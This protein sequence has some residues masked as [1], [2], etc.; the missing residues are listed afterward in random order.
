MQGVSVTFD[1]HLGGTHFK[2]WNEIYFCDYTFP[3]F[4]LA[5][6]AI[7]KNTVSNRLYLLCLIMYNHPAI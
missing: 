1:L 6:L 3:W 5:F 2:P 4:L 7:F